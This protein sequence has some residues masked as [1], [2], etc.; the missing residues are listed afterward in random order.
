MSLEIVFAPSVQEMLS[1]SVSKYDAKQTRSAPLTPVV[2]VPPAPPLPVNGFPVKVWK[3]QDLDSGCSTYFDDLPGC[4][5]SDD[6]FSEN[7]SVSGP[8]SRRSSVRIVNVPDAPP[9]P[10]IQFWTPRFVNT[11][12]Q[13]NFLVRRLSISS[14]S[15]TSDLELVP[16]REGAAIFDPE[17][18]YGGHND[19][20]CGGTTCIVCYETI[21]TAE[22]LRG[23]ENLRGCCRKLVCQNCL[24]S[25]LLTRL[26]DGLIDFP[27]PNPE[28]SAPI[29]KHEVLHHLTG[30]E[31]ERFERLKVNAEADGKRKTC[32]HCCHI[33]EHQIPPRVRKLR[34]EDIK[35][36]CT[37]CNIEWCFKCQAPWHQGMTCK[38]FMKGN[39][40]FQEWT[41]RRPHG[42]PNCQKCPTCRV[43]IQRSSG[44]DHMTCNRCETHFCYKC[45]C[46]FIDLPLIGD[47]YD[48]MSVF[49]C[50]YNYLA[51]KPLKRKTLR[52]S[53]FGA[54]LAML[55]GY[56]VLFVAGVAVVVVVGAVA[57]PVYGVY[58]LHKFRKNVRR[59]R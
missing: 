24:K 7:F 51:S 5:V 13:I 10:P 50:K 15:T 31:R 11:A 34:E 47:H 32:P 20:E 21:D 16:G 27:C 23:P 14:A 30:E 56:P 2:P 28:C 44:C 6:E 49:G 33:T 45:G 38:A 42:I 48:N 29:P 58:R 55:T 54:K 3:S 35:I 8:S 41:K 12:S 39:Q 46:R 53:Y 36:Q 37:N 43:F 22:F 26:N 57:L 4:S 1:V 52:G 40:Q 9:P 25:I 18:P 17:N 19:I 59:V